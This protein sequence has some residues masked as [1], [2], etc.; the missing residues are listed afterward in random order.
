MESNEIWKCARQREKSKLQ[1]KTKRN[2]CL[3][4]SGLS[5]L[6]V[7]TTVGHTNKYQK[8]ISVK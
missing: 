2:T 8:S 4:F 3:F 5:G 7:K 1:R 6:Y